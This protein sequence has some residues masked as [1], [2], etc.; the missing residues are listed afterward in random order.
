MTQNFGCFGKKLIKNIGTVAHDIEGLEPFS[1]EHVIKLSN[2]VCSSNFWEIL[3]RISKVIS[4]QE[5]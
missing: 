2:N 1:C 5:C 4:G 3:W